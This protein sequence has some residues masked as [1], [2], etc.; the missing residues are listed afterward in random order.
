M[1]IERFYLAFIPLFVAF[2]VLGVLPVYWALAGG[3]RR[4]ARQ[5]AVHNAVV[6]AL[7]VALGFLWISNSI[8]RIMGIRMSD[9]MI[10][11]GVILFVL[12]L[13]DLLRP[14]KTQYASPNVAPVPGAGGQSSCG[15]FANEAIGVVPLGVPLIVGPAVLTTILLTRERYGTWAT[16]A[17]LSANILIAWI[18]LQLADRVM[19]RL[20]PQG[21]RVVSKVFGLVLA[22]FAVMLVREGLALWFPSSASSA[23]IPF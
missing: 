4:E 16:I 11:G 9:V 18:G 2:D 14:E 23:N 6:V 1:A 20:G 3:L 22:A 5:Q 7:L 12:S 10:S 15:G 21:A 8:F 19:D 17:A 13:S